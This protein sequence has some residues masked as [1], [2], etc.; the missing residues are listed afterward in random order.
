MGTL[1]TQGKL[2]EGFSVHHL[3]FNTIYKPQSRSLV[4]IFLVKSSFFLAKN[5]LLLIPAGCL[6]REY[7]L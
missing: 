6:Q 5:S 3:S 2:I 4:Y 7:I 1:S